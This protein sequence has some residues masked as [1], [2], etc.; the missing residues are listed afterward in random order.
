MLRLIF[1]SFKKTTTWIAIAA[2][3][4]ALVICIDRFEV[5]R[6]TTGMAVIT[7]SHYTCSLDKDQAVKCLPDPMG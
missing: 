3:V 7:G 5:S 4:I 6:Q 1:E 2:A